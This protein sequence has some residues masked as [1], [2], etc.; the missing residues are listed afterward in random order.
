VGKTTT[1]INLGASLAAAEKKTLIIDFDGQANTTSG[2]GLDKRSDDQNSYHVVLGQLDINDAIHDTSIPYLKVIPAS[3][4]LVAA[5]VELI[6][7]LGR[8]FRLSDALKAIK[9]PYDF[10]LIDC[11]PSLG[12]L[13]INALVA[14]HSVLIPVQCEYYALEGLTELLDTIER[15]RERLNRELQIEGILLTMLDARTKLGT[16]VEAEIREHFKGEVYQVQIPRNVRL[17]EAP[18]HGKPAISYDFRSKGAQSY[19][20]LAQE[21]LQ[22]QQ[23]APIDKA[24]NREVNSGA[25]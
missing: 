4:D 1:A 13:T 5:E 25:A 9:E 3:I 19:L 12:F 16:Q 7:E 18:S 6:N 17:A 10:I 21:F 22:K 15:V 2:L 20:E 8:E 11:P 23:R 14:S 24:S